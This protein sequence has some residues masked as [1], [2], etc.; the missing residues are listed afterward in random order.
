MNLARIEELELQYLCR[1]GVFNVYKTAD[2]IKF[3]NKM[4]DGQDFGNT[5]FEHAHF[6]QC[7]FANANSVS[8][9]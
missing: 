6:K 5:H 8:A 7:S 1:Q 3:E 2:S 9:N 4:W